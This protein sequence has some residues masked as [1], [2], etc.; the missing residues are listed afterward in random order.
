MSPVHGRNMLQR[1]ARPLTVSTKQTLRRDHVRHR[2]VA[3]CL[4]ISLELLMTFFSS[5]SALTLDVLVSIGVQRCPNPAACV[6]GKFSP[7]DGKNGGGSYAC[8]SCPAGKYAGAGASPLGR[9]CVRES[10]RT[11]LHHVSHIHHDAAVC[12]CNCMCMQRCADNDTYI[13]IYINCRGM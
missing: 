1:S 6:A 9:L 12:T 3:I 8:T 7:G 11:R 10:L 13:C 4:V 2:C 5:L